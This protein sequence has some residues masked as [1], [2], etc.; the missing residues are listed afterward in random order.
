ML[1]LSCLVQFIGMCVFVRGDSPSCLSRSTSRCLSP[2]LLSAL[3]PGRPVEGEGD[4]SAR[5]C[6]SRR[7]PGMIHRLDSAGS[8]GETHLGSASMKNVMLRDL[9]AI[10]GED[11]CVVFAG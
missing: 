5:G 4:E 7:F 8:S 2:T 11:S 1:S 9:L 3:I 6:Q 10:R